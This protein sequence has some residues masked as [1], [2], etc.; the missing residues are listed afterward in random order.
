MAM[1][2]PAAIEGLNAETLLEDA[3][4]KSIAARLQ[5]VR[6]Y[7]ER[8]AAAAPDPDDVHDMRV[9]SRRLRAALDLFDRKK[10]LLA[11]HD[12][13]KRLGDAL[14][15]VR[16][17]QVQLRWLDA[18]ADAARE[19]DRSGI[20]TFRQAR[21]RKLGPKLELLREALLRWTGEAAAVE[22]ATAALMHKGR[23][24]GTRV[25]ERLGERLRGVRKRMRATIVSPDA[26][27]AHKLRIGA[28]KLRYVAEL[29]EPAFT[30]QMK[31]LL[32]KLA[33]LQET[34]GDLHDADVH[35]P[36]IEKWLVRADGVAQPGALA[37]LRGEMAKREQLAG[38]LALE[39]QSLD[40][41]DFLEEL[42]DA[43][44]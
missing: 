29:A 1:A 17:L 13:V 43:I 27:T 24:G 19:A 8:M 2:K 38:K 16:E 41:A 10:Q 18:A 34:L 15:G 14:G 21:E 28:K 6:K 35:L 30:A 37:L 20:V 25:R 33:P 32:D 3:A 42:H 7:E 44:C 26:R 4:K 40:E 12:A 36:L 9:A 39:L 5:D 22:E 31:T 11:A 23:L